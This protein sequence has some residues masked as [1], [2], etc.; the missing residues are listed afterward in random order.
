MA[1]VSANAANIIWSTPQAISAST[2]VSTQGTLFT[3]KSTGYNSYTV[4]GVLFDA[5][6][7]NITSTF[8]RGDGGY[9][10]GQAFIGTNDTVGQAYAGLMDFSHAYNGWTSAAATITFTGLTINQEYLVQ[11]WVADYR[12]FTNDRALTLTGGA[13]TSGALRFLDSDNTYGI[14]GSYVIGTFVADA[15]SQSIVASANESTMM[16]AAQLRAI[17]EPSATLLG[18]LGMLCLLRRRR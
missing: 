9:M 18:G 3:A 6:A 2:D 15:T 10:G 8:E 12:G 5:N 4:N 1:A 7:A 11:Y 14:H 13:N 17:P 16:N